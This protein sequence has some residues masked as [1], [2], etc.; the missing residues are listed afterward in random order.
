MN[1]ILNNNKTVIES[2]IKEK[3]NDFLDKMPQ[4]AKEKLI[5]QEKVLERIDNH[6]REK[7]HLTRALSNYSKKSPDELLI[8]TTDFYR[9]KKENREMA[10]SSRPL[11]QRYGCH[12]WIMSLRRP[13]DF[14]GTRFVNVNVGSSERPIWRVVKEYVA[15]DNEKI[16]KPRSGIPGKT[17]NSFFN[18]D[19][20]QNRLNNRDHFEDLEVF[21]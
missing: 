6:L 4:I 8:S 14:K 21:N 2:L 5:T 12:T 10:E 13:P 18:T 20:I 11:D 15:T 16:R 9:Q 17:V 1:R 19:K 7:E 3:V